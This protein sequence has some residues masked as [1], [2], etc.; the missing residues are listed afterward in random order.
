MHPARMEH[1]ESLHAGIARDTDIQKRAISTYVSSPSTSEGVF[2]IV[3]GSCV[4][5]I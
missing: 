1:S 4:A 2:M 5:L 3:K